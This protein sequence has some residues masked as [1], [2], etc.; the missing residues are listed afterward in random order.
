MTRLELEAIAAVVIAIAACIGLYFYD[1]HEQALGAAVCT[2]GVQ[3]AVAKAQAQAASDA[4]AT[5]AQQAEALHEATT[6]NA[7]RL[8][9]A[10]SLASV[11]QRLRDGSVRG[12]AATGQA[13]AAS[14]SSSFSLSAPDVVPGPLF[15]SVIAALADTEQDASDLA[16]Y[17]DCLRTAGQLCAADYQALTP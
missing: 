5:N 1:G 9:D 6:Q 14:G 11:V 7:S 2:T 15:R 16:E 17:A 8:A 13:S 3:V 4:A 12:G 10:R